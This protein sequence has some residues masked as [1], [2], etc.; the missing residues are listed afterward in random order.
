MRR[1]V[2]PVATNIVEGFKRRSAKDK[3]NFYN[4]SHGSLN[5]LKYYIM[6]VKDLRYTDY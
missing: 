5:E 3:V 6:L 2:V 1:A 4:M